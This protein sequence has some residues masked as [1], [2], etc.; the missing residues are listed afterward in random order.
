MPDLV[1]W[2][3]G[4]EEVG[5]RAVAAAGHHS[6]GGLAN[7]HLYYLPSPPFLRTGHGG[8]VNGACLPKKDIPGDELDMDAIAMSLS[9]RA[10]CASSS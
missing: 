10:P 9:C 3:P 8:D 1:S 6:I 4:K 7:G 5:T 2:L